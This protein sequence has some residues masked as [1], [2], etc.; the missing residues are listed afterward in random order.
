MMLRRKLKGGA[1][2]MALIICMVTGITLGIFI[3]I[4][5]FNQRQAIQCNRMSQLGFDLESGFNQARSFYFSDAINNIWTAAGEDSLR[6]KK[7]QWGAYLVI[8]VEA[9]N[10]HN[11]LKRAALYGTSLMADTALVVGDKG[12]PVGVAGKIKFT[13]AAYIPKASIKPAYIDGQS[14]IADGPVTAWL[15]QAPVSIPALSDKFMS[16]LEKSTRD[17]NPAIDSLIGDLPNEL[18]NAFSSKTIVCRQP[19]FHLTNA[20]L[21]G[22]I[23]LEG[24][25]VVIE[26]TSHLENVFIACEKI[27]IKTG[28]KGSLQVIASDSIIVEKGC[29][30]DYPS[31]LCLLQQ[32]DNDGRLSCITVGDESIVSGG[33]LAMSKSLSTEQTPKMLL[34][35]GHDVKVYG[36]V[37]SSGFGHLQGTIYGNALCQVLLYKTSSA[38]YENHLVGTAIDPKTYR[39]SVAIP[40][41][42]N[43]QAPDRC[44]KWL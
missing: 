1:L 4:A 21:K 18:S 10:N 43:K 13:A 9:K 6:V 31:S 30:L 15:K 38:T 36:L 40:A 26:N 22:N 7:L 8:S 20:A 17:L 23:K 44:I 2:Y 11:S 24:N 16:D 39:N 19:G 32:K 12:R 5:S 37:Y 29:E 35:L 34:K 42:L 3:L 33:I 25:D 28:F 14:Y 27:T 41:V